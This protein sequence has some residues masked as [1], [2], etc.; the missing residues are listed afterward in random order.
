MQENT[1]L[2]VLG[3]VVALEEMKEPVK[4]IVVLGIVMLLFLKF[5]LMVL[6]MMVIL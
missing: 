4:L 3:L 6:M 5:V 1:A 2:I